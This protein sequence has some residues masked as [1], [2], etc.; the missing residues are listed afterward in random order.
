MHEKHGARIALFGRKINL[1][2]HPLTF[3]EMLRRIVDGEI[4]PEDAVKA[5]HGVLQG[6]KIKPF[7]N[8][9]RD[10]VLSKNILSYQLISIVL[11]ILIYL[12]INLEV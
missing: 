9:N 1:S 11:K 12:L 6:L 2:E 10:S 4:T 5:Y 3:I 7:R 8:L